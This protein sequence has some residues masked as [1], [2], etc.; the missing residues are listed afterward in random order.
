MKKNSARWWVIWAVVLAVYNVIVFA[1]P[2][3]KNAVFFVSWVFSLIAIA[4][5][6]YVIRTAFYKGESTTSKFYGFPIQPVRCAPVVANL[7][8]LST[9]S[10]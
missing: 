6:V 3:P 1:V 5:Q 9:M 7:P 4:A 10:P 8:P 2:F